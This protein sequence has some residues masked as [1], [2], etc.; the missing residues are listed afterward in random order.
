VRACALGQDITLEARLEGELPAVLCDGQ[1]VAQVLSNLLGNALKFTPCGGAV[2]ISCQQ[3]GHEVVVSVSDTGPGIAADELPH[4]FQRF[5][6]GKH[7]REA[8]TGLGLAI[9]KAI[10]ER[11]G[12]FITVRSQRGEGTCIT[13]SLPACAGD[14]DVTAVTGDREVTAVTAASEITVR[15]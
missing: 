3:R 12:G 13:F 4:V 15:M 6:R 2:A 1:R 9:T 5:Y 10:I 14:R 11:H 7:T 8:G